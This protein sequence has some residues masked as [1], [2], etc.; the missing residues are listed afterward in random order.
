[1]RSTIGPPHSFNSFTYCKVHM[2][3]I[4]PNHSTPDGHINCFLYIA[5]ITRND[6][7]ITEHEFLGKY[8]CFLKGKT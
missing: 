4:L 7:N 8:M 6:I 1:M 2:C 5:M 3:H